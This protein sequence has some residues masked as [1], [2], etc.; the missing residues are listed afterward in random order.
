MKTLL[1]LTD[2][3]S[4][5]KRLVIA[6][7]RLIILQMNCDVVAFGDDPAVLTALTWATLETIEKQLDDFDTDLNAVFKA[8]KAP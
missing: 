1:D 7:I 5:L 3:F 4:D 8:D 2:D 6:L